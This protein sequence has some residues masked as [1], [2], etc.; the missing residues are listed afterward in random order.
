MTHD[1]HYLVAELPIRSYLRRSGAVS[2]AMALMNEAEAS[3]KADL[4]QATALQNISMAYN[5]ARLQEATG[6]LIVYFPSRNSNQH[7]IQ[8]ASSNQHGIQL[9]KKNQHR[10]NMARL[11]EATGMPPAISMCQLCLAQI[12]PQPGSSSAEHQHG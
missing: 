7:S 1:I 2:E 12:G 9:A 3:I 11:Q 5:M 6:M 10:L 4:S 8:H